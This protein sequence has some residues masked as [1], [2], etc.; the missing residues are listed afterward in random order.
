[1][2]RRIAQPRDRG[3]KRVHVEVGDAAG[4][5]LWRRASAGVGAL[6]DWARGVHGAKLALRRWPLRGGFEA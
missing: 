5:G 2:A 1:M 4:E 6:C 3:V